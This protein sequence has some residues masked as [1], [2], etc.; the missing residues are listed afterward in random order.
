MGWARWVVSIAAGL[1][2]FLLSFA[3]IYV[4]GDFLGV[5]TF[6]RERGKLKRLIES[7]APAEQIEMARSQVLELVER[8]AAP[9]LAMNLLPLGFIL[10]GLVMWL[11]WKWFGQKQ[12]DF[13]QNDL[14]TDIQERMVMRLAHRMGG[15]FTI[16]DL[17][18]RSPL[19]HNQAHDTVTRMQQTGQL[20][21]DGEGFRLP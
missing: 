5:L 11:I 20:L 7:E 9:Q 18:N 21:S 13:E 15:H 8:L 17:T 10:G 14:R 6:F 3:I 16:R 2:T 1:A 19:N 12:Q 4:R